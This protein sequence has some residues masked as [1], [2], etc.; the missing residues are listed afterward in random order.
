MMCEY[1]TVKEDCV[2][3]LPNETED[4]ARAVL[5]PNCCVVNLLSKAHIEAGDHVVLVG[6]GVYGADDFTR[7]NERLTGRKSYGF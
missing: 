7:I 3:K 2:V 4:W 1:V 5:E 6:A